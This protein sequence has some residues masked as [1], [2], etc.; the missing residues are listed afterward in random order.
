MEGKTEIVN[1]FLTQNEVE[2]DEERVL[3]K[4]FSTTRSTTIFYL[5]KMLHYERRSYETESRKMGL[6]QVKL[7]STIQR[8]KSFSV[9]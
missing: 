5:N 2:E 6:N 4:N 3:M 9:K 8:R 7:R 1:L